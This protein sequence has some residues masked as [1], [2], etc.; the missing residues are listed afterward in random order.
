MKTFGSLLISSLLVVFALASPAFCEPHK[1]DF[2]IGLNYPGVSVRYLLSDKTSIECKGQSESD[3][4]VAGLRVYRNF[5]SDL[6]GKLFWGLEADYVSFKGAASKGTGY[7]GELFIGG[8]YFAAKRL[9][10]QMDMGP[11]YIA[12]TDGDTSLSANGLECVF[13]LGINYYLGGK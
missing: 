13:N 11:A 12:L 7:A 5:T 2:G 6:R 9:S 4:S 10:I 3:I 8:E 1:G